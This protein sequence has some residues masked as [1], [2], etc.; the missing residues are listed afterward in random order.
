MT[1]G[2]EVHPGRPAGSVQSI[3]KSLGY[4]SFAVVALGCLLLFAFGWWPPLGKETLSRCSSSFLT[5]YHIHRPGLP[6]APVDQNTADTLGEIFFFT[7]STLLPYG[8]KNYSS[9]FCQNPEIIAPDLVVSKLLLEVDSRF[10]EYGRC[11]LCVDGHS[12][13]QNG[14]NCTTGQYS[15]ECGDTSPSGVPNVTACGPP[16]GKVSLRDTFGRHFDG[17]MGEYLREMANRIGGT[18]YSTTANG[19]C[20]GHL[21]PPCTWRL[22]RPLA[23]VTKRCV[24]DR[25]YTAVE[26]VNPAC[27][28]KCGGRDLLSGCWVGCFLTTLFGPNISQPD[29]G[30]PLEWIE[31]VWAAPFASPLLGGCP[32][33]P[34]P[35]QLAVQ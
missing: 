14:T 16:V 31:R 28:A 6:S 2:T 10:G 24:A 5:V 13:T 19:H 22:A 4:H 15:C 33:L 34:M 20:A 27:F 3:I 12:I 30:V 8:C 35:P 32:R 9:P 21:A 26:G 18:W 29:G 1:A 17:A 25:V 7:L 23:R 11:N